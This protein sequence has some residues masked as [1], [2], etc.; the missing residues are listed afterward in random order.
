ME[1]SVRRCKRLRTD[2]KREPGAPNSGRSSP[3]T[4]ILPK[5]VETTVVVVP[6]RRLSTVTRLQ[7]VARTEEG[8][9]EPAPGPV[10]QFP[11]CSRS[12]RCCPTRITQI[13]SDMVIASDWSWVTNRKVI[14]LCRCTDFR[15][16]L[17]L[18]SESGVECRERLVEQDQPGF[19]DHGPS[20]GRSLLLATA[21]LGGISSR[22]AAS[23]STIFSAAST[24]ASASSARRD[25]PDAQPEP[26]IVPDGHVRE[27]ARSPGTRC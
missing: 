8:G 10:V 7:D 14:P 6:S 3:F 20:Q 23:S 21:E 11:R 1:I 26:D 5:G 4:L 17:H 9:D 18:P 19:A 12:A 15:N 22:R 27:T 25:S 16:L 24:R 2:R 13:R